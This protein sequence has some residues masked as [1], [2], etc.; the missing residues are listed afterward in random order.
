MDIPCKSALFEKLVCLL[1]SYL[2]QFIV[3][4]HPLMVP[5]ISVSPDSIVQGA[6][7]ALNNAI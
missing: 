1:L 7:S 4:A 6:M 3:L 2:V 5:I